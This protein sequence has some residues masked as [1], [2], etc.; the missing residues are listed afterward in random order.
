MEHITSS[1]LTMY[2]VDLAEI[3]WWCGGF[4]RYLLQN[5]AALKLLCNCLVVGFTIDDYDC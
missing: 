4:L 3:G 1:R 5:Y 2:H